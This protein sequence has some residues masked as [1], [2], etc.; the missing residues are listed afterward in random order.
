MRDLYTLELMRLVEELKSLEGLYIDQFYELGKGRF[1]IRLSKSGEKQNIQCILSKAINRT[2]FIELKEE[3]TNFSMAARKRINGLSITSVAQYNNDRI[4]I[5][6]AGRGEKELN[7]IFEMFG[8]GN[9]VIADSNMKILLAYQNHNF[10]DRAI[11]PNLKYVPPKNQSIDINDRAQM[12]HEFSSIRG[13]KENTDI[14]HYL[15]K[16]LGM[17]IYVGEAIHRSE[18]RPEARITE[19]G[20][21]EIKAISQSLA[22]LI[23]ECNKEPSITVYM[24]NGAVADFSLCGI[25]KYGNLEP[26]RFETLEQCLDFV[27]SN[28]SE[29][30]MINED[31]ERIRASIR[32][33]TDILNEIDAEILYCKNAGNYIMN[34]MSGINSIIRAINANKKIKIDEL[35]PLADTEILN[36]DMKNKLVRIKANE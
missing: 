16:R 19:L 6:K 12:D 13:R 10:K 22:K 4:I 18:V 11:R 8:R 27:Y 5:M 36:I 17:N 33:Q 9:L 23:D 35:K 25:A 26:K 2:E 15:V 29:P 24:S 28:A 32:K 7:I 1:R 21:D 3:A 20:D 34:H 30:E 31:A 14:M